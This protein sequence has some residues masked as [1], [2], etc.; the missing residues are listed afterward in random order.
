MALLMFKTGKDCREPRP[1]TPCCSGW[2][3]H[4]G[5]LHRAR[6]CVRT[7][8]LHPGLT[9]QRPSLTS[10]SLRHLRSNPCP[11][12]IRPTVND[13]LAEERLGSIGGRP[14][15]CPPQR[16]ARGVERLPADALG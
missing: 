14:A 3:R 7:L 4:L 11:C 15:D 5:S 2:G 10:T 8:T 12:D 13:P 6:W 16:I 1:K 9:R